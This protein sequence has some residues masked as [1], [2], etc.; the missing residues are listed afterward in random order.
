M[1]TGNLQVHQWLMTEHPHLVTEYIQYDDTTPFQ[2]LQLAC[3][4]RDLEKAESMHG[5]L[6]AII[7]YWLQY[8][9][10]DKHITLF[11]GLGADVAV[12][13][14]VGLPT[15][16]QWG[17]NLDFGN[18]VFV[19][20]KL[21]CKFPLHYE[22]TKQGLPPTVMFDKNSFIR[23]SRCNNQTAHPFLNQR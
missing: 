2:P 3:A 6:A 9:V 12:N 10:N 18:N 20:P 14:I 13:S 7:C 15:L 16:R 11:F 23:P 1:N 4:V 5:K 21:K 17:G 8:Q 22:P 19:A